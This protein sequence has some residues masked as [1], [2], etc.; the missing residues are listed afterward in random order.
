MSAIHQM[1]P[2][3]PAM[4]PNV[5]SQTI[6]RSIVPLL[7]SASFDSPPSTPLGRKPG[8]KRTHQPNQNNNTHSS[9][10]MFPVLGLD[11][12]KVLSE[13]TGF[14]LSMPWL[15][16]EIVSNVGVA[17]AAEPVGDATLPTEECPPSSS[18]APAAEEFPDVSIDSAAVKVAV[19]EQPKE[20]I[21]SHCSTRST[22]MWRNG[23]VGYDILCNGCG[24]KW[25]RGRILLGLE[26]A[27]S[28]VTRKPAINKKV[29]KKSSPA[30]SKPP[31]SYSVNS[32]DDSRDDATINGNGKRRSNSYVQDEYPPFSKARNF[33]SPAEAMDFSATQPPFPF[34]LQD[35]WL[36]PA[37]EQR[38]QMLLKSALDK[39]PI[40]GPES[41]KPEEI[42]RRH[43][44]S[45]PL[46]LT[47]SP[48]RSAF[49]CAALETLESNDSLRVVAD[50]VRWIR[51]KS[52][53]D[54][55]MLLQAPPPTEE[56]IE[57]DVGTLDS[58]D[59]EYLCG[60]LVSV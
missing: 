29:A 51:R 60:I 8:P 25:K 34:Q 46:E 35:S 16:V 5:Q 50:A 28:T 4:P 26:R 52:N 36:L 1:Y 40:L 14:D 57:M 43:S 30:P 27:P 12:L 55:M 54:A 38:G 33:S 22:P 15:N 49:V 21:C 20:R 37:Q 44:I 3:S 47:G 41:S 42:Q 9:S 32:N 45:S 18:E 39:S 24:V 53:P 7:D 19:K 17:Q 56:E 11:S 23:P 2:P 31:P 58:S 13:E 6:S 59:W 10:A 48:L